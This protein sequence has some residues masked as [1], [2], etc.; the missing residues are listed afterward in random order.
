MVVDI[1]GDLIGHVSLIIHGFICN[2]ALTLNDNVPGLDGDLDPLG[3]LEQFLGVAMVQL[4]AKVL[5]LRDS[6]SCAIELGLRMPGRPI[7]RSRLVRCPDVRF[8]VGR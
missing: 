4:S 5:I 8:R 2:C 7:S 1:L 6:V 3:D